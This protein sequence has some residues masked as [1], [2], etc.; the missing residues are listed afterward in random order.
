MTPPDADAP[1]P[2]DAPIFIVGAPRSGTTLLAAMLGAHPRI[3][4]GPESRVIA[5]FTGLP[6]RRRRALLDPGRWPGPALDFLCRLGKETRAVHELYGLTREDLAAWLAARPPSL[7][8]L[9][10]ALTAQRAE[11]NGKARWAEKT[12]R[13]LVSVVRIR[14]T[15]PDARIVRIV[16][17]P[18]DAALSMAKTPFASPS[19]IVDLARLDGFD[20]ASRDFF[21][22]DAG[23][24]TIRY[25]DL[26]ADP[27]GVLRRICAFIG[28][29]FDRA[30]IDGRAAAADVA[31]AHEWWK[32]NATAAIDPTRSGRWRQRMDAPTQRFAALHLAGFLDEHGYPGARAARGTVAL[33][34]CGDALPEAA[35]GILTG[36]AA[37]DLVILRPVPRTVG[38]LATA[39]RVIFAGLPGQLALARPS[40]RSATVRLLAAT[41]RLLVLRA[42]RRRPVSWVAVATEVPPMPRLAVERGTTLLLRLLARRTALAA[43]AQGTGSGI[44]APVRAAPRRGDGSR[45]PLPEEAAG[46]RAVGGRRKRAGARGGGAT[47]RG[48]GKA[49]RKAARHAG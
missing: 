6:A 18:R 39:E 31:P 29:T 45:P 21:R 15:W 33:V 19:P 30:M 47:G 24:L 42:L 1:V 3:D 32:E 4:C 43:L 28:E 23:A 2:S 14:A 25:E 48:A 16:R 35:D 12:P 44:D 7:A 49:R 26:V 34:P 11:R 20:R 46:P 17:D 10:E 38:P 8:A 13:H 27:E 40:G 36:L 22:H 9:E 41:G 5:R 37:R